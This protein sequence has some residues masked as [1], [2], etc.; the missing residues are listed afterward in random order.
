MRKLAEAEGIELYAPENAYFSF[1]N[2]PY[3]G[4]RR[5]TAV[6]IYPHHATWLGPCYAPCAGE[7]T[8]IRRL[9][10]GNTKEF[11]TDE[12]DYALGLQ[13]FGF[14]DFRIRLLHCNST[15]NVGDEVEQGD[16]LGRLVRSRYF[17]YWTGPHYHVEI[18]RKEAFSRSTQSYPL[19]VNMPDIE[20]RFVEANNTMQCEVMEVTSDYVVCISDDYPEAHAGDL[21][22]HIAYRQNGRAL[23]ILDGGIP[24]YKQGCIIG[25]AVPKDSADSVF[26]I[27]AWDTEVG[28]S[29]MITGTR[30]TY[31]TNQSIELTLGSIA[32]R[33]LSCYVFTDAQRIRGHVPLICIPQHYDSLSGHFRQG[34]IVEMKIRDSG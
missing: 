31:K 34:D 2:S 6:D 13:P 9:K 15:L 4:H 22:G 24:H 16:D 30:L 21:C 8:E 17:N 26:P 20:Y 27:T 1:C 3:V 32:L 18:M 5:A 10:M 23:G 12:Y 28:I 14:E 7:V 11:P 29:K 33:G 25:T 19:A